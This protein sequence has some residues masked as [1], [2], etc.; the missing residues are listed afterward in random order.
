MTGFFT[1]EALPSRSVRLVSRDRFGGLVPVGPPPSA[2]CH[3]LVDPGFP[4]SRDP[5]RVLPGC[6]SMSLVCRSVWLRA[7]CTVREPHQITL[8][9][10]HLASRRR[11]SIIPLF[12]SE[13][14]HRAPRYRILSLSFSQI[15][16]VQ[17]IYPTRSILDEFSIVS[18][19]RTLVSQCIRS[20][21]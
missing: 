21:P 8:W 12:S 20:R 3:R 2:Y 10:F 16:C 7:P 15:R 14:L 17:G 19:S 5:A 13:T 11:N 1:L 4:L 18:R 9:R 6:G